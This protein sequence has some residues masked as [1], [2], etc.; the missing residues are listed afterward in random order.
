MASRTYRTVEKNVDNTKEQ[1]RKRILFVSPIAPKPAGIGIELRAW[2]HLEALATVAD[3]DLV[4]TMTPARI[5]EVSLEEVRPLCNTISFIRRQPNSK[6]AKNG[7]TGLTTLI[8]AVNM[9]GSSHRPDPDDVASICERLQNTC[10]DI[11]FCFRILSY[12]VFQHFPRTLSWRSSRLFVDFDDIESL[13][14]QR[15]LP[16]L[17]KRI[18]FQ[19]ALIAR[20]KGIR[21]SILESMIR[22][23]ADMIGV[24]S[25]VDRQRLESSRCRASL[26]VV[27]NSFP[28]MPALPLRPVGNVAKLLFVGTISYPPNEDAILYFC[29]RILP[30]IR[31]GCRRDIRLTIVGRRPS[32]KVTALA[33]GSS[34]VVAGDVDSVEPYY[35]EADLVVVP[36][37]YGGGTRI[38]I[39][40]ALS[41]GRPVVSTSIGAE[42]LE[43]TG[44]QDL[45]IADE[46]KD[47]ASICIDLLE[48]QD[49]RFRLATS[50]RE[51]VCSTYERGR[52]QR[53]LAKEVLSL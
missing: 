14:I 37:R 16:F 35:D 2:S 22:R 13:S 42:G 27:P 4:L 1:G 11:I 36:I 24:C 41:F 47:F 3:I 29:E 33:E 8:Y 50:G 12:E 34:I 5:A 6:M 38:K 46:E 30:H 44:G 18:G 53:E 52:I 26:L 7:I 20:I 31:N 9:H 40:E 17:R 25:E 19:G 48:N 28:C 32:A 15:E 49:A 43:L 10:F 21:T 23:K 51:R 39:L 45:A